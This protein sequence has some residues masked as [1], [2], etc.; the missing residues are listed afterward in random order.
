MKYELNF[1]LIK[2][3]LIILVIMSIN[4]FFVD[5][6]TY[7]GEPTDSEEYLVSGW[8]LLPFKHQRAY[9][10]WVE[11]VNDNLNPTNEWSEKGYDENNE[12]VSLK[13]LSY[14]ASTVLDWFYLQEGIP[15]NTYS[16]FVNN[17]TENGTNHREL[18]SLYHSKDNPLLFGK[19]SYAGS[20]SSSPR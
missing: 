20:N 16:N 17:R 10:S 11:Y 8:E 3:F 13:C 6:G 2:L 9:L 14:A 5:S 12:R 7:R 18:E 1:P 4:S 15:L 19:Y